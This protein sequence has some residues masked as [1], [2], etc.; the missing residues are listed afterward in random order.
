MTVARRFI[1]GPEAHEARVPEGRPNKRRANLCRGSAFAKLIRF[2]HEI[3]IVPPGRE[4]IL[5]TGIG[6]K[7]P[8]YFQFVP[9]PGHT[10]LATALLVHQV[11]DWGSGVAIKMG[12]R[13]G[14]PSR[15]GDRK[16]HI[17]IDT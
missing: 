10:A 5:N 2:S 3:S 15:T 16:E 4:Q 6:D 14:G 13:Q 11:S 7:S 8:A 12:R 9:S 17:W 1:A